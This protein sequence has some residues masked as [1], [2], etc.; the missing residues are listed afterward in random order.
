MPEKKK[1]FNKIKIILFLAVIVFAFS[2][3]PANEIK[4]SGNVYGWAWTS[5]IGWISF[6]N[7]GLAGIPAGGGNVDYGA[8]IETNGD[9]TGYAWSENIG[10]IKFDPAPDLTAYPGCGYPTTPCYSSQ[11]ILS[12]SY[13]INGWVRACSVFQSGCSGTLSS[14]RG[15]WDGWLK[16]PNLWIDASGSPSQF[17]YWTWGGSSASSDSALNQAV[18]GWGTFN[19]L[20]GGA[21]GESVCLSSNYKV[22]TTFSFLPK[23]NGVCGSANGSIVSFAPTSNLCLTGASSNVSGSGPWTWTCQ[24]SDG[25]TDSLPC[26]ANLDLPTADN[27]HQLAPDYCNAPKTGNLTF[28]WDYND[29]GNNPQARFDFQIAD[30]SNFSSLKVDRRYCDTNSTSQAVYVVASPNSYIQTYCEN[31]PDQHNV[32]TPNKLSYNT[33]YY[34]RVRVCN[35]QS[36]CS[37]WSSGDSFQTATHAYPSPDFTPSGILATLVNNKANFSFDAG[38]TKCYDAGNNPTDCGLYTWNFGKDN[39]CF[40]TNCQVSNPHIYYT[41]SGIRTV[42]L[43]VTDKDGYY[44]STHHDVNVVIPSNVPQWQEISPFQ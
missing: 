16:L 30:N 15:G 33:T 17:H 37:D 31:T 27:P 38:N 40:D 42:D 11:V 20:E 13:P 24:G 34:W 1:N 8:N 3:F 10:W 44:C 9:I 23:I 4:A 21:N 39:V 35:S 2:F 32:N 26:T 7:L 5:N 12:A 43:T 22:A 18:V 28:K 41:S 29:I 36:N 14:N 25:G 19:C 6:N